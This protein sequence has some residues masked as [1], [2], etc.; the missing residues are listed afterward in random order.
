MKAKAITA[1][2]PFIIFMF[3]A[4]AKSESETDKISIDGTSTVRG[5]ADFSI[6]TFHHFEIDNEASSK[7]VAKSRAI[8]RKAIKALKKNGIAEKNITTIE[9]GVRT[10][11][12][13]NSNTEPAKIIGYRADQ[14]F[15]VVVEDISKVTD[16]VQWVLDAGVL[17]V[18]STRYRTSKPGLYREKALEL[19]LKDAREKADFVCGAIGAECKIVMIENISIAF[20]DRPWS[21]EQNSGYGMSRSGRQ[22][23]IQEGGKEISWEEG[24][25]MPDD[26][27]V[28]PESPGTIMVTASIK[29]TYQTTGK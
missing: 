21:D 11:F 29:V 27:P 25:E 16:V 12:D 1:I 18:V 4:N 19:A 26:E 8:I 2:I 14:Q 15:Q 17:E 7:A 6:I 28:D 3:S 20:D 10:I 23:Y 24:L 22:A 5:R 9:F 13:D